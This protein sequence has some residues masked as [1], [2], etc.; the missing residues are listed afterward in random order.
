MR[1]DPK[2]KEWATE[3]QLKCIDAV[4]E[5]GW[6][7]AARD[8]G[9]RLSTIQGAVSG[10]KK[11]AAKAGYAPESD[12]T[13]IAPSPFDVSG[14][15]THYDADGK[16]T[17][18][19]VKTKL[20]NDKAYD[21]LKEWVGWLVEDVKGK[22]P[23]IRAPARVNEDL[24]TVYPVG[25]PHLG[26]YSWAAETGS[27]FDLEIAERLMCSAID[28][29]V[30]CAPASAIALLLELGDLFHADNSSNATPR[31]A[32][33]LDVDTRWARVL[34][35]GLRVMIYTIKALLKKHKKVIV[36]L[37]AGN[38]DPHTSFAL[39]LAL[40]A[41]FHLDDRVVVDLSPAVHWYY[42][43]GKVLIGSTHGDTTKVAALPGVMAADRPVDW[44]GTTHR[45]WYLG[46][47]H[48]RDMKE[49]PGVVCEYFRTLAA[50]DA[51]HSQQGYRAGRDMVCIVH[52]KNHGEVERHRC[53]LS[54]LEAV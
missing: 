18:Q 9:V 2:L 41:F 11:R 51:W 34:Q 3:T 53:D 15:S 14:V 47:I 25:D 39:S 33:A 35:I 46:H 49:F 19:W 44:G 8:I 20:N 17:A 40:D 30:A 7:G 4:N 31:N 36:K 38:H 45:Y 42:T 29:L 32:N 5:L 24:L 10:V 21:A 52:H 27:D 22:S 48:H 23:K 16:P 50:R 26:M 12:M 43:F 1:I 6:R 13:H 54:M 37:N 28:R